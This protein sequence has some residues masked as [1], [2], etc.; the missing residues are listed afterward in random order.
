MTQR[1]IEARHAQE[2]KLIEMAKLLGEV[3]RDMEPEACS[4]YSVISKDGQIS[5]YTRDNRIDIT[6]FPDGQ[7]YYTDDWDRMMGRTR[8][9]KNDDT[10]RADH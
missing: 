5:V 9:E 2:D 8:K 3:C 1:E 10:V 6:A 4:V 7:V